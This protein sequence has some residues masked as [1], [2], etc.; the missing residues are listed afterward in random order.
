MKTLLI[1]NDPPYGTERTYNGLH[2]AH[3]LLKNDADAH[4][5]VFLMADAVTA[6]RSGQKTR[7]SFYNCCPRGQSLCI[8]TPQPRK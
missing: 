1:L 4:V 2:V 5:S 6:A 7:D 8:H 3:T